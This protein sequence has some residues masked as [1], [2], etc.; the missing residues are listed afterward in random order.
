M[1]HTNDTTPNASPSPSRYRV[2]F[3]NLHIS[4]FV[5]A[6][7]FIHHIGV[8][9]QAVELWRHFGNIWSDKGEPVGVK[10]VESTK[11]GTSHRYDGRQC[12]YLE[13]RSRE[14]AGKFEEELEKQ[15]PD[16][17]DVEVVKVD[18]LVVP[19]KSV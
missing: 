12:G 17:R 11:Y 13:F 16:I 3:D 8:P 4:T 10:L 5:Q 15:F 18:E 7:T 1:S 19:S 9:L 6:V 14:E 2:Y